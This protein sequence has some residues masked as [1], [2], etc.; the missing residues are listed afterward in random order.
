MT[1]LRYM[2]AGWRLH[3]IQRPINR[4]I[5]RARSRHQNAAQSRAIK[6]ADL[7]RALWRGV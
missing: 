5:E 2:L 3:R 7:H 1:L 6:S 4:Q